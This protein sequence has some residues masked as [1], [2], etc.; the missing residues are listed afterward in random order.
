MARQGYRGYVTSREFGGCR[1]PV[2]IQILV[3]RDYAARKRL[4]FKLPVN[5]NSFPHSYLVL[6]GLVRRLSDLEG[7]LV[8]S[9]FMLPERPERRHRL[10]DHVFRQGAAMHLVMEDMVIRAP[11]DVEPVE[12]ILAVYH[13]LRHCPTSIP[14]IAAAS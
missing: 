9:M 1:I 6:E 12:D 3:L 4:F 13:S 8:C 14:G 10:Y 7:I 11:G 5:E 2:P